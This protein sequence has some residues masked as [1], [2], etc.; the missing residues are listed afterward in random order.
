MKPAIY[1]YFCLLNILVFCGEM[2]CKKSLCPLLHHHY[3][4]NQFGSLFL[5][6][7]VQGCLIS[8]G[9]LNGMLGRSRKVTSL[10][11]QV[12]YLFTKYIKFSQQ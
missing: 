1:D 4:Y 3:Y 9:K 2:Y 8:L 6:K 11:F 12:F 7:I 10:H 5:L